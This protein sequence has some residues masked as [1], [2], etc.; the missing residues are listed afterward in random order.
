M[1]SVLRRLAVPLVD[2]KII[3]VVGSEHLPNDGGYILA[4]NH[5][6]WLDP[7]YVAAGIFRFSSRRL[8][9]ISATK[10]SRWTRGIIPIEKNDPAS[11]LDE[12]SERIRRGE[13]VGIFPFGDQR[14]KSERPKT[15]AVRLSYMTGRPIVP[16]YLHNLPSGHT[17]KTLAQFPFVPRRVEVHFGDPMHLHARTDVSKE[18]L[19]TD[20]KRLQDALEALWHTQ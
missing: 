2:R 14:K 13:V 20:M 7:M 8:S 9:F 1:Y 12:A 15:G 18:I 3:Q 6:S 11:C 19:Y 17:W 4:V 16:V 10:K 5:V